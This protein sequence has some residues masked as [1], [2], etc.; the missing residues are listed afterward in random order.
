MTKKWF[1][2]WRIGIFGKSVA[3]WVTR[4]W[5]VDIV[6]TLW[7]FRPT[8]C[9]FIN[10]D[11]CNRFLSLGGC[12]IFPCHTTISIMTTST[13]CNHNTLS[14]QTT[15]STQPSSW[16][17]IFISFDIYLPTYLPTFLLDYLHNRGPL[18]VCLILA[19]LLS[20]KAPTNQASLVFAS[21][22]ITVWCGS[23]IVT[24]NAQLLGGNI[25]FFQSVCVLGYCIFPMTVAALVIDCLKLTWFSWAWLDMIWIG[26][27]FLWATR[28]SSVFIGLYVKKERRF[29][30]VFP[31]L[32]FYTFV[33]WMIL[34]FWAYYKS[35]EYVTQSTICILCQ[36]GSVYSEWSKGISHLS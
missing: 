1:K 27:A 22:F 21:V 24:L 8:R 12:W 26:V 15:L 7:G 23:A 17:P 28:A 19:V 11:P 6:S 2:N 32:F 18:L 35:K 34:L 16:L 30:A 5:G 33:G 10:T 25:S 31:V 3:S 29:L 9:F 20:F 36:R 14:P 4:R 13:P